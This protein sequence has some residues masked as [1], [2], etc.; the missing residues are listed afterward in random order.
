MSVCVRVHVCV[1]VWIHSP[2]EALILTKPST[3]FYCTSQFG[4]VSAI[5][6]VNIPLVS[7]ML[8]CPASNVPF[9]LFLH[10]ANQTYNAYCNYCNRAGKEVDMVR[11]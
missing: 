2:K 1:C 6:P 11:V 8:T 9:T 3:V 5:A 7:M 10:W 4:R